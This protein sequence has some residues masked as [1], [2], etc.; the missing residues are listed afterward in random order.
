M[1]S[2]I[3]VNTDFLFGLV[4]QSDVHHKV[5][6]EKLQRHE[7]DVFYITPFTIPETVTVLS[8]KVSQ[9]QARNFLIQA[10]ESTFTRVP[11]DES[12][13]AKTDEIFLAQKK[14]GTSW[15]DCLNVAAILTHRL[16]GILSFD[17][18]Y[19]QVGIK[20]F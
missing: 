6:S 11:L 13:I 18:F 20:V 4:I 5:A 14:K 10:R 19:Q 3:L 7:K 12:L 2:K 16:D 15:V 9:E 1:E 8:H 17:R